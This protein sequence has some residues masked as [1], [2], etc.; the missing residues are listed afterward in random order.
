MVNLGCWT[1][2]FISFVFWLLVQVCALA[3]CLV[4]LVLI[5]LI[6]HDVMLGRNFI[7]E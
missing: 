5:N 1:E 2:F 7:N 4:E 6:E 3:Y